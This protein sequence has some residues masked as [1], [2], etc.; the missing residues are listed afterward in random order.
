MLEEDKS[1]ELLQDILRE[2]RFLNKKQEEILLIMK[3]SR[4]EAEQLREV[5]KLGIMGTF[6]QIGKI[7]GNDSFL[8]KQFQQLASDDLKQQKHKM[9]FE[10]ELEEGREDGE[11]EDVNPENP[12]R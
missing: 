12:S 10:D 2:L 8:M 7:A 6:E 11:D 4:K 3:Q 9:A 1:I 5:S